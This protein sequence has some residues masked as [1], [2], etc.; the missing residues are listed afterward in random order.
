MLHLVKA[1]IR[2]ALDS[3]CSHLSG[4]IALECQDFVNTYADSLINMLVDDL[5]PQQVCVYIKL[6][7]TTLPSKPLVATPPDMD[8]V[9]ILSNEI[10]DNTVN[11]Q[12]L[13][14]KQVQN[15]GPCILCEFAMDKIQQLLK[16]NNTEA[17]IKHVVENIC[18]HLPK[19]ISPECTSFVDKYADLVIQLLIGSMDPEDIC[20]YVGLCTKQIENFQNGLVIDIPA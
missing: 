19:S 7:N 15:N 2:K 16:N 17:E 12:V 9:E 14:Q 5:K 4:S 20:T 18:I 6:C 13:P 10:L 11:G 8:D 1:N 3:L